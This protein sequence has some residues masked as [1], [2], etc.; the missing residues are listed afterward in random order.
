MKNKS[1]LIMLAV[2]LAGAIILYLIFGGNIAG[3]GNSDT[4][5]ESY[6]SSYA[7]SVLINE[8]MSSNPGVIPASDGGFYDWVELY[9]PTDEDIDISNWGLSDD[10]SIAAKWAFGEGTVIPAKGY[11][12]IYC[13]DQNH[14]DPSGELHA[15]FKLKADSDTVVLSDSS[16]KTVD[17]LPLPEVTEGHS[18]G[19]ST[20]DI[21]E[22]LDFSEP[23]PGYSNDDAGRAAYVASMDAS[24]VGLLISEFQ[25]SNKT[26]IK[27]GAGDYSDWVEIYNPTSADI[28]ISGFGLSDDR[29]KPLKWTFPEGTVIPA[30]GRIIVWCD[31]YVDVSGLY[32]DELHAT[33]GLSSYEES[34]VLSDASGKCIDAVDYSGIEADASYARQEDGSWKATAKPTPGYENTDEGFAAFA[35]Q[36]AAAGTG[37]GLLISEVMAA[38]DG[39]VLTGNTAYCDWIE[40]YNGTGQDVDLSGWGL[41]DNPSNPLKWVFPEGTTIAAGEYKLVT[42]SGTS[43][44]DP[45][46]SDASYMSTSYKIDATTG[47]VVV[48]AKPDGT[49]MDK[50]NTGNLRGGITCGKDTDGSLHYYSTPTPGA[51]NAEGKSTYS[52]EPAFSLAAG[53]Y[54]GPQTIGIDVPDNTTVYYTTDGTIPDQSDAQYTG[55]FKIEETTSVRAVA[56]KDG[57]LASPPVTA[58]YLIDSPHSDA[59]S[60]VFITMNENDLYDEN[61]GIYVSGPNP[62]DP[63]TYKNANFQKTWERECNV[64]IFDGQGNAQ[65][66]Q[67]LA[68]RIFGAYSRLRDQKGF[69]LFARDRYGTESIDY[70][71]FDNR[72]TD[73]YSSLVLRAG[74]QDCTVTKIKDIVATGLVDGTTNLEVQ[75]YRQAV[76]YINGEYFGVYNIREKINKDFIAAHYP[77]VDADNID[78]LVGNGSALKGDNKAYKELISWC[79]ETDFSSDENYEQLCAKIDVDNYIDYLICE[80]YVANTDS[81]N[82]KFFRER[83]EDPVN[84]KWRWLYYDFCWTFLGPDKDFV[85]RFTD[86]EGH[87]VGK[88]FSTQLTRSLMQNEQFQQ[89]FINRAAEL[90]NT[91]YT[92]ENVLKKI[93]ECSSAIYDEI[94]RDGGDADRWPQG[95]GFGN[96]KACVKSMRNFAR[97]RR[98]YM[99]EDIQNY[100]GLSDAETKEIFGEKD[101]V[102]LE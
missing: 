2:L 23:T 92:P 86:P 37:G 102:E 45:A 82:I 59:L 96:W 61:T 77:D 89:K 22:W 78:L 85:T 93:D 39:S 57:C 10:A 87:G 50:L 84:S 34:V 95:G 56:Y 26:T 13:S 71:V 80:M 74:G 7:G 15:D 99:I 3:G 67:E 9:N 97:Q 20:E 76:V 52:P 28:D 16:G 65:V 69:A 43:V 4:G 48:L 21:S 24:D 5:T 19:R 81:G 75:A 62:G 64:E 49:I 60:V 30:N 46:A 70:P 101:T 72:D 51:K 12:L 27:D 94:G 73:S 66:N 91:I 14:N 98:N 79:A 83:S 41:S 53:F 42:A 54:Y 25:P 36:E 44:K 47:E 100:F 33:F 31:G 90:L 55:P 68:I 11:L 88:G 18:I 63:P 32:P 38:D 29:S 40:L 6:D 58:S 35:Q 17:M 8:A 1:V